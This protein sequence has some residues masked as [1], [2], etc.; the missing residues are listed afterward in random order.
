VSLEQ[1]I[2]HAL[3]DLNPAERQV[4]EK[5]IQRMLVQRMA[6]ER[7][8][9]PG[10]LCQFLR[11]GFV[12]T[13]A[14]DALDQAM[15]AADAGGQLRHIINMPP[16]EGKTTR[17]QD[18]AL[19]FL[20][21]DPTRRIVFASYEQGIAQESGL[22]IRQFIE[23][24][25]SGY[26]GQQNLAP[27]HE[28]V[29]GLM[30][31]PARGSASAWSLTDVPGRKR[32]GGVLSV[33]I[34]SALT[35]RPADVLVIDDPLKDAVQAD[36]PTYRRRVINW[37][38]SV[39]MTRLSGRA[40]VIVIQTRWHEDDLTGFL[41][42]NDKLNVTPE[43]TRLSIPA[44]A[45]ENDTLGRKPG[46]WLVSTRGRTATEWEQKRRDSGSGRWWWAMYQQEPAPLEGG[47]FQAAWFERDRLPF[48]P[49]MK[50]TITVVDPADNEGEGDEAGI[51]TGGIMAGR[52]E[53][54]EE[55]HYAILADDSG[56]FTIAGWARR[57]IYSALKYGSAGIYY[58]QSLSGLRRALRDEWKLIKV[59]ARHL[60]EAY[61][62]WSRFG[63][64]WPEIPSILAV[65][66]AVTALS[67]PEDSRADRLEL[68]QRLLD[69]WPH[70]PKIRATIDTG[71]PVHPFPAKGSK[72]LRA[73]FV[74]PLYENRRVHHVGH[75]PTAERQMSTWQST[76]DSPDRMDA[77][78]HLL[79]KLSTMSTPKIDRP[80]GS[81]PTRSYTAAGQG[82]Q[83][84]TA[85]RR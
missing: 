7:F 58:E 63:E 49:E 72:T 53:P 35:G 17:I 48:A 31:D 50:Y 37:V 47:I 33:G 30:L 75:M 46:E 2:S 57:A 21:R 84:S 38:Q 23:N 39:A 70:V 8:P 66:D 10:H 12:Q 11:P 28:D 78:V 79:T 74:A 19:W 40:I 42:K 54:G 68:R 64:A 26:K 62:Q 13:P 32:P 73:E 65:D 82:I 45:V 25:G 14:L 16:Q 52:N 34:G 44:Q 29:L 20:L 60:A 61:V 27:D 4:A 18:T 41:L 81:M 85:T 6:I 36:S 24:H 5:R 3:K 43:W 77:F 71:V 83:R 67:Q 51:V 56:H 15:M 76:Q 69:M 9:T 80:T 59:Q 1:E 22:A 55:Q